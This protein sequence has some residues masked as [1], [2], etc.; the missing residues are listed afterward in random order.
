MEARAVAR[1]VRMSPRKARQV[2]D[3]IR[4]KEVGEA[5]AV[6]RHAPKAASGVIENVTPAVANAKNNTIW[7]GAA[8]CNSGLCRRRPNDEKNPTTSTGYSL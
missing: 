2:V 1:Y 3:S 4:G 7:M 5:L 6:L 8:L